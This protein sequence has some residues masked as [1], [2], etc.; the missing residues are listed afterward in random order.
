[1]ITLETGE[2]WIKSA[3]K[4]KIDQKNGRICVDLN[5][6]FANYYLWFICREFKILPSTPR[7]G[8]HITVALEKIHG[9]L[10]YTLARTWAGKYIDFEY[11]PD[12]I[13]GGGKKGHTNFWIKVRS[14]KIKKL[15]KDLNIKD[16]A[17]YLGLHCTIA[18]TKSA[19][20]IPWQP[21]M[22]EIR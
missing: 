15:K 13:V 17:D 6:D 14:E 1:M 22:I 16:K 5:F 3:G 19:G 21:K 12:I 8:A 2:T 9:Q 10:P 7:F 4:L 18:N 20:N 11:N